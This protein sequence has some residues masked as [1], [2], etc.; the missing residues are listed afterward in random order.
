[1]VAPLVW[2][3][4]TA[5]AAIAASLT[6][7]D[8]TKE[9]AGKADTPVG[10]AGD[11]VT[12]DD[13]PSTDIASTSPD[14]DALPAKDMYTDTTPPV[15]QCP[16]FPLKGTVKVFAEA[17]CGKDGF[18][19]DIDDSGWG[20]CTNMGGK[21]YL[22]HVGVSGVDQSHP[23]AGVPDQV[24]AGAKLFYSGQLKD[25]WGF[26]AWEV[27]SQTAGPWTGLPAL[28]PGMPS[29]AKGI[30]FAGGKIFVAT[31]NVSFATGSAEY[32][33][34]T[35]FAFDSSLNPAATITT[36]QVNPSSVG[37][38]ELGGVT[39]LAV[40]G[41]GPLD[42]K[43]AV[44]KIDLIDPATLKITQTIPLPFGGL[45]INGEIAIAG[46]RMAIGSADNS[47]RVVVLNTQDLAAAP[48]ILTVT[49]AVGKSGMHFIS[50][51]QLT[52][53]GKYL[54]AGNYNTGKMSVWEL[55]NESSKL[56]KQTVVLDDT[57]TDASG[58]GDAACINGKV[59]VTVGNQI[60]AV[61]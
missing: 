15:P 52:P 7:C 43:G 51:T 46:G 53:D 12:V 48:L 49:E 34:G 24:V 54:V 36:S 35:V 28:S 22:F 11:T 17:P 8:G 58:I 57:L 23:T 21:N 20:S 55:G 60:K 50:M 26:G 47:G 13:I 59:M 9:G 33:P 14:A 4:W 1:M 61:E 29:F 40:V 18:I 32:K 3:G 16:G 56:V 45:G 44:S 25:Q 5:G 6:G 2:L 38:F 31:S 41:S 42:G 39:F 19:N 30:D 37:H 27:G 10:D